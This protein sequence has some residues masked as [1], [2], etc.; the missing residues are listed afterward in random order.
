V[1]LV[2]RAA[3]GDDDL[4][5][6]VAIVNVTSPEDG[7][8]VADLAWSDQ[9]YPGGLRF[10]AEL[11]GRIV[12]A[13]TV[14]RIYVHPPGFDAYWATVGVLPDARR[15]GAGAAL[16]AAT[17]RVARDA[18]KTYLHVP[19]VADR[20]DAIVFLEHRGFVEHERLRAVRLDLAAGV[21]SEEA[22]AP[23]GIELTDLA[24]R[25]DLVAGVHDVATEAFLDIPGADGPMA[26]GDLAEFRARDV[27]RPGIP[28]SGFAIAVE[29]ATGRVVGYAALFLKPGDP[30]VGFHDMTAVA[31]AWRRRGLA[32]A[33]KRR[34]IDWAIDHGLTALETG[35]DEDNVAMQGVNARLGYRSMPD[36]LTMRG[37]LDRAMMTT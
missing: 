6:I 21:R 12:G 2:V 29:Q 23:D 13:A 1:T 35:N 10:L 15:R 7:T 28:P 14:G 18:G 4:A 22:T 26:T 34:T 32:T 8:S 9:A 27:D 24:A 37:P 36:L 33:L 30:T 5:A 19:T 31:R 17:A 3:T 20:P 11:D 25:P 16:L